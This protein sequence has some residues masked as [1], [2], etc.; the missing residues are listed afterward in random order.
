MG[1]THS[2]SGLASSSIG[3]ILPESRCLRQRLWADGARVRMCGLFRLWVDGARESEYVVCSVCGW[4]VPESECV[5]ESEHNQN[6]L[7]IQSR[8]EGLSW[9]LIVVTRRRVRVC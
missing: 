2:V 9:C 7:T 4:M 1:F 3:S 5:D 8:V 6:A